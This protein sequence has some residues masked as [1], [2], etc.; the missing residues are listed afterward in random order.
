MLI[1]DII[2]KIVRSPLPLFVKQPAFWFAIF[3]ASWLFL[4]LF[5]LVF[6]RKSVWEFELIYLSFF[7]ILFL[8]NLSQFSIAKLRFNILF[9]WA[10][11]VVY[12]SS[13]SV[14]LIVESI[15][16]IA[17]FNKHSFSVSIIR[18]ICIFCFY[19]LSKFVFLLSPS[20]LTHIGCT[21]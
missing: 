17:W 18:I 16:R 1:Y 10:M 11:S 13:A 2:S 7:E 21:I 12:S 15:S 4:I 19:S 6:V 8:L 9:R 20:T 14:Q 3:A 5:Q